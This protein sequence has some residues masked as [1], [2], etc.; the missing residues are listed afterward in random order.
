MTTSEQSAINGQVCASLGVD[1]NEACQAAVR[2]EQVFPDTD[3]MTSDQYRSEVKRWL[4]AWVETHGR[5]VYTVCDSRTGEQLFCRSLDRDE[6][7]RLS[8][9]TPEGHFDAGDCEDLVAAGLESG[10]SV[11]CVS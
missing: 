5:R 9:E 4:S 2:G 10:D 7:E 6:I 1:Y 8:G 3:L 11:Y